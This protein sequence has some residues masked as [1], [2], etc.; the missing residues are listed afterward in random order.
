[1]ISPAATAELLTATVTS[2]WV[3]GLFA[4][5]LKL[6]VRCFSI[7]PGMRY[8]LWGLALMLTVTAPLVRFFDSSNSIT[9]S[10]E[11]M[12]ASENLPL[13]GDPGTEELPGTINGAPAPGTA[14]RTASLSLDA[15][16][17]RTLLFIWVTGAGVGVILLGL[18]IIGLVTLKRAG[19]VP[20]PD[21]SAVWSEIAARKQGRRVRLLISRRSEMPAACGYFR[22]AIL[23]PDGLCQTLS[24]EETRHLLLHELAHLNRYDDWGL[25]VHRLL[26]SLLWWHPVVWYLSRRLDAERE[27]ACDEIVVEET[28]RRQ[29]AR[30]L[31]RVAEVAS[32]PTTVLAPGILRGDLTCRIES[33]LQVGNRPA[34]G[35][36]ARAGAAAVSAVALAVWLSPPSVRLAVEAIRVPATGIGV[37]DGAAIA[38]RLDSIFTGYADSG[39]AGS[40]LLAIGDDI[41]LS[42]GYGLADRERG[43]PATADTRY[44]VAGFTKMFTA[45]AILT[46]EAEGR[47]R[48]SDSMARF[49]AGL[50][51]TDGQVTLHQLLTH[52]D[53]L[54]RQN[55][56]VYRSD[57]MAFIRA[58]S[59]SPDSF[60][61][62]QGYRYNDFGHSVLGVIVEQASGSPYEQFIHDRFLKPAGLS[63]TRFENE[64]GEAY[65]IEYAGSPTRQYPIPP[66]SYT[67]GRR[68]SLGLVSTV[69]DMFRWIRAI[70]DPRVLP[71]GVR[72]RMLEAHGATDWG[73]ERGYGWDR[74]T[75]RDGSTI[76]R[77]VAGTP[78]MEGEILH[79]PVTGWTAVILVNSRVEWRFRVWDDITAAMRR[80]EVR[81]QP[82]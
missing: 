74:L 72:A 27:L 8:R 22:A 45:A 54:T 81:S 38:H 61:P 32:G 57:P 66:R 10:I 76:W 7:G 37:G 14:T 31:V 59:A 20:G 21:L 6:A 42:R 4:I 43:I 80:N 24:G 46:L 2:L 55:A 56:P 25:L 39:F 50:P 3:G 16:I 68:G 11:P 30:T 12:A 67:W 58:V 29:Y 28:S 48:V 64:P 60:A 65:A 44:S 62:G 34:K 53:G 49:F 77:R 40:I 75:Q 69:G 79:D 63:Q 17:A 71:P 41:I 19:V 52:T 13:G 26:Q 23:A 5:G 18:Q 47:L 82:D 78:G 35:S 73:A 15:G 36:R 70:H 1:M 33:L 9:R 51:G